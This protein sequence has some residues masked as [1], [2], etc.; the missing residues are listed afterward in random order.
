[1]ISNHEGK[2]TLMLRLA[3]ER[4]NIIG[5]A[6]ARLWLLKN[7]VSAEGQLFRR[8]YELPL[9][10]NEHPAL[11]LSWTLYHVLDENSPLYGQTP[12]DL[13][14]CS[15]SLVAVVSGYDVVAAQTIHARR[16]YDHSDI[17]FGHA[18]ADILGTLE[19][20]RVRIDYS[21]L[22]YRDRL[23]LPVMP[24]FYG[25]APRAC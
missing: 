4:H 8:F 9:V 16:P 13:R 22:L 24:T 23:A 5:N 18:Y 11:A 25:H 21:R 12:E 2:P 3:N 19:D 17:L 1:V 10:R 7:V 14:A 20:G 15:V 6:S